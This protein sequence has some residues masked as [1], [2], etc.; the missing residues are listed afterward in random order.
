[1]NS[2]IRNLLLSFALLAVFALVA[3]CKNEATLL[4]VNDVVSDPG[5]FSG[6]ITVVGIVYGF[7]QTDATIAGIMDKKELQCTTPNC[8]KVLLPV[9]INGAMPKVGAE[10]KVSGSFTAA[11]MGQVLLAE[12]VEVLAQHP[13][14]GAQ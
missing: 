3:G 11:P 8:K 5:A 6:D 14:G 13:L 12:R 2:I 9:K 4:Q 10:V 1:M 7:A